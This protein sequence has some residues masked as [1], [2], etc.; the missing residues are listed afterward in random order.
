MKLRLILTGALTL[1]LALP[2]AAQTTS[3]DGVT[4]IEGTNIHRPSTDLACDRAFDDG[5]Y[6]KALPLCLRSV[7]GYAK[8]VGHIQPDAPKNKHG[9]DMGFVRD[10]MSY[11]E[12]FTDWQIAFCYTQGGKPELGHPHA[13]HAYRLYRSVHDRYWRKVNAAAGRRPD[14]HSAI[15]PA[16]YSVAA[17]EAMDAAL[18]DEQAHLAASFVALLMRVNE[19]Y[20][21]VFTREATQQRAAAKRDASDSSNAD[22]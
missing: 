9:V 8:I 15:D 11:D 14:D 7:A 17:Q 1:A 21:D 2:A 10:S 5:A 22:T 16:R 20:P 3:D 6:D 18:S 12:A 19:L 4:Q 13:A